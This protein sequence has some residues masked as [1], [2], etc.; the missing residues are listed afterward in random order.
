MIQLEEE[1]YPYIKEKLS[2]KK[3]KEIN[4]NIIVGM[5]LI[6]DY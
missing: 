6:L 3:I 5:Y 1:K 2:P 4:G